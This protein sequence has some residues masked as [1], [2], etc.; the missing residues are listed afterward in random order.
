MA[1][2]PAKLPQAWGLSYD[3]SRGV[4]PATVHCDG[5][6]DR[7]A[8]GYDQGFLY[9]KGHLPDGSKFPHGHQTKLKVCPFHDDV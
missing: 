6:R 8:R 1:D 9:A 4:G 2:R 5:A 7:Q 3:R